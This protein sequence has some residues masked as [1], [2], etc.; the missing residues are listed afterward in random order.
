M[1]IGELYVAANHFYVKPKTYSGASNF[2]FILWVRGW[3]SSLHEQ[4][5]CTLSDEYDLNF[6]LDLGMN[7][8]SICRTESSYIFAW[9]NYLWN[10]TMFTKCFGSTC[11]TSYSVVLPYISVTPY[12]LP[13]F[14]LY[15]GLFLSEL[16]LSVNA[17]S[18]TLKPLLTKI[19][20]Y[21]SEVVM[22]WINFQKQ[23][24]QLSLSLNDF[25]KFSHVHG[26]ICCCLEISNSAGWMWIQIT[27]SY[28]Q[29][30]LK[31]G[32]DTIC[33]AWLMYFQKLFWTILGEKKALWDKSWHCLAVCFLKSLTTWI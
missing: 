20:V 27:Q 14:D 25:R 28:S 30:I 17:S 16:V 4:E 2:G 8:I 11:I 15:S 5:M 13:M 31:D 12:F 32:L 18:N 1:A 29:Y 26:I 3:P 22:K 23:L 21:S 7:C 33:L 10:F 24:L 19:H 9:F 6:V